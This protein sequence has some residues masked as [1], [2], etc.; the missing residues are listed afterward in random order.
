[1][2]WDLNQGV[3]FP[4]NRFVRIFTEHCL[5]HLN[6][7]VLQ[8]VL[9]EFRRVL[10]PGGRVRIV[11]PS[12]AI[13]AQNYL[14]DQS[15]QD[16]EPAAAI[17]RVFYSGHER[18]SSSRWVNDGHHYMHDFA[19]MSAQ[20][21]RAGFVSVVPSA[22]GQGADPGLVLDREDRAWESLYVEA[23]KPSE[24]TA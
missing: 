7:T 22:C 17:N 19:S 24:K 12:L 2:V 14:R 16:P 15:D 23:A 10:K 11:V 1:M 9:Q 8:Q 3:P 21:Q 5:E 6:E 18:I 20:L 4:A 13:H